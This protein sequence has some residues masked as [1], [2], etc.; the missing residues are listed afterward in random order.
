MSTAKTVA[1]YLLAAFGVVLFLLA[2]VWTTLKDNEQG[3]ND[4]RPSDFL[5]VIVRHMQYLLIISYI[6]V[7]WPAS[8]FAAFQAASSVFATANSQIISLDCVFEQ[9]GV[10]LPVKR[11]LLYVSAP[12]GILALVLAIQCAV[13][14]FKRLLGKGDTNSRFPPRSVFI[15]SCLVVV[16]TFYP[17]LVRVALGFFACIP[18]D[19]AVSPTDPY[20]QFAIANASQGYW[21]GDMQQACWEGWHRSWTLALGLPCMLLFCFGVPLGIFLALWHRRP[22]SQ[23][24]VGGAAT[25]LGFL[26]HNYRMKR[27]YWEVVS[28]LQIAIQVAVSVFSFTLG[29]YYTTLLLQVSVITFWAMQLIFKPFAFRAPHLATLFSWGCL[30]FTIF[31]ALSLFTVDK[32]LPQ[33]YGEVVGVAGLVVNVGFLLWCMYQVIKHSTGILAQCWSAAKALATNLMYGRRADPDQKASLPACAS[34]DGGAAGGWLRESS[35]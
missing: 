26:F 24:A 22:N 11:V 5:K 17:L 15:V 32:V 12:F 20:P 31:I 28:T 25:S 6:R 19:D 4:V 10:P 23:G 35:I 30:S 8:L 18:L 9:S 34:E 13:W 14:F 1:F 21:V 33:F 29:A 16:F 7:R 3:V 27:Y 2:M